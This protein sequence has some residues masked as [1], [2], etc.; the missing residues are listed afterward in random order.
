MP[1]PS[2]ES[3]WQ[4]VGRLLANDVSSA[5]G[6]V[7]DVVGR[8]VVAPIMGLPVDM[9]NLG[10]RRPEHTGS[11]EYFGEQMQDAGIVSPD[12][13][14]KSELAASLLNPAAISAKVAAIP[15]LAGILRKSAL[16]PKA[17]FFGDKTYKMDATGDAVVGDE[18]SFDRAVF[19]GSFRNPRFDGYQNIKGK[20][21]KD[22]YGAEKQQHTF[23]IE[24]PDGS[25][26]RIKGRNL[27]KEGTYRKP[28]KDES[29]RKVAAEE[30][31]KRGDVAREKRAHR[32]ST[33]Y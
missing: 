14:Y 21:I 7:K 31:H 33:F 29:L 12:R 2:N 30:K 8:G 18:V 28:W 3:H 4:K 17:D 19:S 23:T 24:L 6:T 1:S 5:A 15:A 13:N 25:K 32:K 10:A 9:F 11:S 22:S 27:Y 20:I 26:T 16:R